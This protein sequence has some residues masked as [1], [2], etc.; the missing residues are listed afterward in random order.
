MEPAGTVP[1]PVSMELL[2]DQDSTTPHAITSPTAG[3]P[4]GTGNPLPVTDLRTRTALAALLEALGVKL[5]RLDDQ[6]TEATLATAVATLATRA[7]ETTAQAIL[8]AIQSLAPLTAPQRQAQ[9]PATDTAIGALATVLAQQATAARQDTAATLLT[10][11]SNGIAGLPTVQPLPE[12]QLRAAAVPVEAAP[13]HGEVLADQD[14]ADAVLTF[15]FGAAVTTVWLLARGTD[16]AVVRADPYGGTPTDAVGIPV[17]V[18]IPFPLTTPPTTSVAVWA[19]SGV[20]VT[21]WGDA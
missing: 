19:P 17:E 2:H 8:A 11:I 16:G 3:D 7:A 18:G 12:Q 4:D 15:H 1:L 13:S 21:V 10:A 14:G 9:D 20:T 6:A 5:D